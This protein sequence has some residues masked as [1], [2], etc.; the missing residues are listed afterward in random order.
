MMLKLI[1]T[2]SL[3]KAFW[4]WRVSYNRKLI[5]KFRDAKSSYRNFNLLLRAV[6]K[7]TK[8]NV[9]RY[10]T[11]CI[12]EQ[13]SPEHLFSFDS[14]SRK[15]FTIALLLR[16]TKIEIPFIANFRVSANYKR[17]NNLLTSKLRFK[18]TLN[19]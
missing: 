4:K 1:L 18:V 13:D 6:E 15:W 14:I 8:D 16:S 17:L 2:M 10:N 5:L 3:S 9:M 12:T 7:I 19:C 11:F